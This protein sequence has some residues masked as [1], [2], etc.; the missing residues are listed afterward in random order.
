MIYKKI[1]I[2]LFI[3]SNTHTR[4][5]Q[6]ADHNTKKRNNHSARIENILIEPSHVQVNINEPQRDELMHKHQ[7]NER[8]EPRPV[9][10]PD[11][12]LHIRTVMIVGHHAPIAASAMR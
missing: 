5:C 4:D 7:T 1:L 2:F 8:K 3:F 10:I 12:V 6:Y 9:L 11:A